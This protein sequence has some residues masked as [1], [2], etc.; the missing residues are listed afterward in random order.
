MISFT[1]A[2]TK[3]NSEPLVRPQPLFPPLDYCIPIK[4]LKM[5]ES[6]DFTAALNGREKE[7]V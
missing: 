3:I 1:K 6:P 7:S 5:F 2:D 4:D